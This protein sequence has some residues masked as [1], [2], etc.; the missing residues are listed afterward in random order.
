MVSDDFID[1][2]YIK[3]LVQD[4]HSNFLPL[5]NVTKSEQDAMQKYLEFETDCMDYDMELIRSF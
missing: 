1:D 4:Y 5:K 3:K 2:F